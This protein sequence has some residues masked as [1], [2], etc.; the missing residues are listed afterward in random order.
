MLFQLS[1]WLW[2]IKK[3]FVNEVG[4]CASFLPFQMLIYLLSLLNKNFKYL[5]YSTD[6]LL[7]I[8]GAKLICAP[9]SSF[10]A[11]ASIRNEFGLKD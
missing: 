5:K 10:E 11:N 7:F 4:F 2:H 3:S 1:V 9:E 8:V 6:R